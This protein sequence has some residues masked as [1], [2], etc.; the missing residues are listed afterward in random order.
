M[1]KEISGES[2]MVRKMKGTVMVA[3]MGVS[4]IHVSDYIVIRML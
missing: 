3:I 2:T 1:I 4:L